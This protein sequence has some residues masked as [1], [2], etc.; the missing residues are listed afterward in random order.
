MSLL[1]PI[2]RSEA[3]AK[4]PP[5]ENLPVGK[6]ILNSTS[7][8]SEDPDIMTNKRV[9]AVGAHPDDIEFLY[10]GTLLLLKKNGWEIHMWNLANGSAGSKTLGPEAI[11]AKRWE[12]AQAS[13]RILGASIH[14]P[15]FSDLG[16]FYDAK[17]LARVASVVREIDPAIILT[18]PPSD[19]MEDHEN[20]CRLVVTAGMAKGI[21]NFLVAPPCEAKASPVALYHVPPMGCKTGLN[22]SVFPSLFVNIGSVIPQKVQMLLTHDSQISWLRQTQTMQ[23]LEDVILAESKAMGKLSGVFDCAEAFTPHQKRGYCPETFHPLEEAL[24]G[25]VFVVPRL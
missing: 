20:T 23:H 5:L 14:P 15:L 6:E 24:G 3:S 1:N 2:S 21:P 18:H 4:Q 10:S 12:E 11:A 22:E 17:S 9:L 13:A 25:D 8:T 16:I 19:Y 7:P